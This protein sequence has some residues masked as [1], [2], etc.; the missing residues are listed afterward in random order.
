MAKFVTTHE[1]LGSDFFVP[2][3][4]APMPKTILRYRNQTAAETVGLDQLSDEEWL[5]H[6]VVLSHYRIT[7]LNH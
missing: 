7:C 2:V 5:A 3:S 1:A 6:L 4:P